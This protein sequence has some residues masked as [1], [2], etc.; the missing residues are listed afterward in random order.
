MN[1]L[2]LRDIRLAFKNRA[3]WFIGLIFFA[4]FLSLCAIALGGSLNK[5]APLAPALIWLA[6]IFANL[7]AFNG[8]FQADFEDG[9]LEQIML[10]GLGSSKIAI[11]KA[12]S[13]FV[14]AYLPILAAVPLAGLAFALPEKTTLNIIL[15]LFI[16]AP[17]LISYGVMTGAIMAGRA[18]AG[19]FSVILTAPFLIP[20][21]IFGLGAVD[22]YPV[23]GVMAVEFKALLGL[24]LI[25]CAIGI[26]AAGAA[27]SA[28]TE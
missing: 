18:N 14:T 20:I 7:L 8:L 10:S 26:P 11:C 12:L 6:V 27:L 13:F 21:L 9:T 3:S 23:H 5:M 28:N 4:L 2:I 25:G 16:A 15:A 1:A 22:S 17:A 19:V 24:S